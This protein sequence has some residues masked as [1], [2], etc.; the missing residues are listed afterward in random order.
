MKQLGLLSCLLLCIMSFNTLNAQ[1]F[2]VAPVVLN[3]KA[4]PGGIETQK[5]TVSNHDNKK[6]TFELKISD[7]EVD[8]EGGKKRAAAGT[9]KRSCA[10]W[11]SIN[12]PLFELE[13][14]D[15][16]EI[17][18]NMTV[19]SDGNSTRWCII[20]VAIAKEQTSNK[21][22]KAMGAGVQIAPRIV[23]QVSQSPAGNS[24]YQATIKNLQ[25]I[26]KPGDTERSFKVDV[27]NTGDKV[28]QAKV[29]LTLAD[30]ATAKE[31]KF[32]AEKVSLYPD[33]TR[34]VTLKLPANIGRGKYA[35]AAILDYGHGTSL[36]GVQMM[37]DQ[38]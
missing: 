37:I 34:S 3:F 35:L 5:I 25:E 16:K 17:E 20:Y 24:N 8:A 13:P 23:I 30:I 28:I 6:Q 19:P 21:A 32:S 15:S 7:Y 14:N 10:N 12:P 38:K 36:E 33:G 31:Q 11:L 29:F 22:D 18:V 4:D 2:E 26:T 27:V 9:T 1:D